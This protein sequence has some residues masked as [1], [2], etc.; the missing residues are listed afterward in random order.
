MLTLGVRALKKVNASQYSRYR[1]L[2]KKIIAD[3]IEQGHF[4]KCDPGQVASALIG[5]I[6]GLLIQW[7]FDSKAF[8]LTN[9][10]KMTEDVMNTYLSK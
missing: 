8:A 10:Q 3:G 1:H 2:L 9:A 6:E 5:M 4:K 7:V